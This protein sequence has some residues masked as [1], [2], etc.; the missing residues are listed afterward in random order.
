MKSH[1]AHSMDLEGEKDLLADSGE[2][3]DGAGNTE[4][5]PTGR[6]RDCPKPP[7]RLRPPASRS[8]VGVSALR[9]LNKPMIFWFVQLV[10][11]R[12]QKIYL[13]PLKIFS[14]KAKWPRIKPQ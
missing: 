4:D 7:I 8:P 13:V 11:Q 9:L 1:R 14:N 3:K 5:S 12:G 6:R 2:T 10:N